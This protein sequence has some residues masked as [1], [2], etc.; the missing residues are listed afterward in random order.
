MYWPIY[1]EKLWIMWVISRFSYCIFLCKYLYIFC[2]GLNSFREIIIGKMFMT[3][4]L[5]SYIIVKLFLWALFFY[6]NRFKSMSFES[7]QGRFWLRTIWIF[8]YL[9][10]LKSKFQRD[11]IFFYPF[12]INILIQQFQTGILRLELSS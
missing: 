4:N 3:I 6:F 8:F 7:M 9:S 12:L 5:T 2:S 10:M 11:K 1:R